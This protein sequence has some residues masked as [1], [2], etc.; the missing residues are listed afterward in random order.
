[1]TIFGRLITAMATPF[2]EDGSVDYPRARQLADALIA[3]GTESLVVAGS[4]GEAATMTR[5]EKS[6]LFAEVKDAVGGRAAIIAGTCSNDTA[7]SVSFSREAEGIGVDAIL[8]TVPW[9]NKPPQAGIER[10]FQTIADAVSIPI[11]LYNVPSRTATNMTADTAVKLSHVPNIIGVKEASGDLGSIG[12][13]IRET[14]DD[15]RVWSGDDAVTLPILAL[16]GYG[17]VSVAS[18][19]V[20]RQIAR[21]IECAIEGVPEEAARIHAALTPIFSAL[22]VTTS[23]IPLKY[24]LARSG[25]PCGSLRLPLIDIDPKS[26]AVMDEALA[27]T[28]IDLPAPTSAR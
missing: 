15:F 9:Y 21:M 19:L 8:G 1:M 6:R 24:G 13:I 22:F 4:T 20:G 11:I 7:E 5:D 16:G 25:F 3:S 26:A 17:V 10:H 14:D 23:P 18:H 12:T 28:Q 2:A 27:R